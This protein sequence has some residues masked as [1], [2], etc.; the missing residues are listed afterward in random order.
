MVTHDSTPANPF[1]SLKVGLNAVSFLTGLTEHLS[2]ASP[3]QALSAEDNGY[4]HWPFLAAMN[5]GALDLRV[6]W[7]QATS[8]RTEVLGPF[9]VQGLSGGGPLRKAVTPTEAGHVVIDLDYKAC[10]WQILAFR[11]GDETLVEDIR[12]GG[13][14]EFPGVTDKKAVKRAMVSMLNG[15]GMATL[16]ATFGDHDTA[17]LFRDT[18]SGHLAEGGKWAVAGAFLHDLKTEAVAQGWHDNYHLAGGTALQRIE[19]QMLMDCFLGDA[20]G[21]YALGMREMLPMRDGV[22]VSCPESA[23]DEV[24]TRLQREMVY[25][26]TLDLVEAEEHAATWV[27]VKVSKS[28]EGDETAMV[29]NTLRATALAQVQSIASVDSSTYIP[30]EDLVLAVTVF[31]VE[32]LASAKANHAPRSRAGM[33]IKAALERADAAVEWL[34]KVSLKWNGKVDVNL[35]EVTYPN[36]VRILREDTDMPKARLSVRGY[37]MFLDGK[38]TSDSGIRNTYLQRFCDRYGPKWDVVDNI[39]SAV[40]DASEAN[41]Y[42]PV[43]DYFNSLPKWDGVD[44]LGTWLVNAVG[45]DAKDG[46]AMAYGTKWLLSIV[47]RAYRP[48]CKVDSVLVLSGKQGAGKSTVLEAIAP[49]GDG[50]RSSFKDLSV[51]PTDKDFRLAATRYAVVEWGEMASVRKSEAEEIKAYFSE[52]ED[53]IRA[54]YARLPKRYPRRTVFA[55]TTNSEEVLTDETGA[56]RFWVVKVGDK[57]DVYWIESNRDQ[58]WAQAVEEYNSRTAELPEGWDDGMT[59]D[60]REEV[61]CIWWLTPKEEGTKVD[62]DAAYTPAALHEGDIND[63]AYKHGGKVIVAFLMAEMGISPSERQTIEKQLLRSL[64][65]LGYTPK[66]SASGRW[67]EKDMDTVGKPM[68]FGWSGDHLKE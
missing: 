43:L 11:S 20:G 15:A 34:R 60:E 5:N 39:I 35:S 55:A 48:G 44:R 47:A 66:R 13:I 21:L 14:Y 61:L 54:P 40:A 37:Q 68:S 2:A 52:Q 24:A 19:A 50:G 32:T 36:I 27:T 64:R 33:S 63:Y 46:L 53:F 8:L 51:D 65:A 1:L 67:W 29:G 49:R 25:A 42:D 28:W 30:V 12:T 41:E 31:R 45:C 62:A 17:K 3:E 4:R 23:A 59:E 22:V 7:K 16:E 18:V 58:I 56:R 9:T 57:I 10:H 26:C 38:E 6:D